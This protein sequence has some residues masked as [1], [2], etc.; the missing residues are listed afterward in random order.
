M[1]VMLPFFRQRVVL[2][3]SLNGA[4]RLAGPAINALLRVDIELMNLLK[5]LC[6]IL[7]GMD[8][9]DRQTSTQA[10]SFTSMHGSAIV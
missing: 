4:N 9:I 8:T 3:N 5:R 10:V 2:E 6:L 7:R 1:G